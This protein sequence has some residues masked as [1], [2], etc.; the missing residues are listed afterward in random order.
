MSLILLLPDCCANEAD[1]VVKTDAVDSRL[2]ALVETELENGV[3]VK[4]VTTGLLFTLK[5]PV[6][7]TEP[8][9]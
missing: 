8:V 9:N 5:L 2:V 6:I 4:L 1:A 3:N 7:V